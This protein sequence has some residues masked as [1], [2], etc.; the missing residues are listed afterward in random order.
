MILFADRFRLRIRP[1]LKLPMNTF[2]LLSSKVAQIGLKLPGGK[3]ADEMF[4]VWV[5]PSKSM[6]LK[7]SVATRLVPSVELLRSAMVCGVVKKV[8]KVE[9]E[10][11]RRSSL[12]MLPCL[13]RM[14]A[15]CEG[16]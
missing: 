11:R 14:M 4:V 5:P 13:A 10:S 2:S 12:S 7:S 8:V 3:S 16:S 6:M 1:D 9:S 15:L